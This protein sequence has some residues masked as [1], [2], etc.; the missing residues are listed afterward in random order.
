M[1]E[2]KESNTIHLTEKTHFWE[3]K[4]QTSKSQSFKIL[5]WSQTMPALRKP[6]FIC[7]NNQNV[8]GLVD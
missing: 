4:T 6:A 2:N 1:S 7:L 8:C 3:K 5:K